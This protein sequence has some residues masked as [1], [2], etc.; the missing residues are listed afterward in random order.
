M[1]LTKSKKHLIDS[2]KTYRK[3]FTGAFYYGY[4]LLIGSITSFIHGIFPFLFNGIA[5][6][7]IIDTYYDELHNH[8]NKEYQEYIQEKSK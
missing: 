5:A 3:H 7:I 6:K 2:Q 4:K 1:I 8:K